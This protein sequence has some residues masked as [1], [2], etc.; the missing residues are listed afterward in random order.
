[1]A[2]GTAIGFGYEKQLDANGLEGLVSCCAPQFE[3][4]TAWFAVRLGGL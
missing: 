3:L 2:N 1:M 4:P